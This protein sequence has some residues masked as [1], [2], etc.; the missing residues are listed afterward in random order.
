MIYVDKTGRRVTNEK[1]AYNE[2]AQAF[3]KWDPA[4]SE[5]PNLV[6]IAIWDQ[7]SQDNSASDEYGRFIVPKGADDSPRHQG[8]DA[9]RARRQYPQRASKKYASRIGD[10]EIA[11]EFADESQGDDQALQRLRQGRAR[12]STSTAASAG[13]AALQRAG[14]ARAGGARTRP[15]TRSATRARTTRRC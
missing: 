13:R 12:I 8:R 14:R 4:K 5:Y 11:D 7:R 2:S 10:L 6:L 9:R 3:F 15:C 1:L